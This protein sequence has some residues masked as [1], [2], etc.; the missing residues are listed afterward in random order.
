MKLGDHFRVMLREDVAWNIEVSSSCA[1]ARARMDPA[2]RK[3]RD[4]MARG[5]LPELAASP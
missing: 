5:A 3:G 2:E 4:V 1:I